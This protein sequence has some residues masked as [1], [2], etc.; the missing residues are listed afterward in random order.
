VI[1]VPHVPVYGSPQHACPDVQSEVA[2]QF[3]PS[4]HDRSVFSQV[5]L[6]EHLNPVSW[7]KGQTET[8]GHEHG[9]PPSVSGQRGA[10]PLG[11]PL[12]QPAP[13][14]LLQIV[15]RI[16]GI[17]DFMRAWSSAD[18][19]RATGRVAAVVVRPMN[20]LVKAVPS[21]EAWA[22]TTARAVG[23]ESIIARRKSHPAPRGIGRIVVVGLLQGLLVGSAKVV[24]AHSCTTPQPPPRQ[25]KHTLSR[26]ADRSRRRSTD[27]STGRPESGRR[28]F[29]NRT[30]RRSHPRPDIGLRLRCTRRCW[31]RRPLREAPRPPRRLERRVAA[32]STA[33]APALVHPSATNGR[34]NAPTRPTAGGRP[35]MPA[36]GANGVPGVLG[37]FS[38]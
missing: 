7:P 23:N 1:W 29:G 15:A 38:P 26:R 32:P 16:S 31:S 25:G 20:G 21:A 34:D 4:T 30:P 18:E 3:R 10:G 17:L 35:V 24:R 9:S 11:A 22:A 28:S 27:S 13:R 6:S 37:S 33:P 14:P 8:P 5:P 36:N 19:R 2:L 12:L